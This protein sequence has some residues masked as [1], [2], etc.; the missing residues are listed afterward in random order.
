MPGGWAVVG[1]RRT[2]E[3]HA[4][5]GE[6]GQDAWCVRARDGVLVAAV[7]DGAGSAARGGAGAALAVRA[8]VGNLQRNFSEKRGAP[9]LGGAQSRPPG[10]EVG[11]GPAYQPGGKDLPSAPPENPL[12]DTVNSVATTLRAAA[13]R[14]AFSPRDLACTLILAVSTGDE[15][16]VAQVGDGAAVARDASG[17]RALSWPAGGEHA[18]STYFVTDDTPRIRLTHH[19]EPITALALLTDGLERMVLDFT[20]ETPHAPFFD[21]I[22]AIFSARFAAAPGA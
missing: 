13:T 22:A 8:A 6:R 3:G 20:S 21:R 7:A 5:R 12:G 2:G 4:R 11:R 15:T 19:A 14:H 17:W 9:D 1:A 18:G 10:G 16:W